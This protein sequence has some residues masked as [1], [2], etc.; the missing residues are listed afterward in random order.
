[1]PFSYNPTN[2]DKIVFKRLSDGCSRFMFFTIGLIF[3][4]V[5]GCM[6]YFMKSNEMPF[7]LFKYLLPAFGIGA[8]YIGIILPKMQR[9]STPDEI[10]FDNL[11][12][13]VEINQKESEINTAYIYYDEIQGFDV[14]VKS[15]TN[16]SGKRTNTHYTYHVQLNKKDGGHWELL[17]INSEL[18]AQTEITKLTSLIKLST[19]PKKVAVCLHP[20][21]KYTIT[22][23]YQKVE[24]NW[25][26][27]LGAGPLVLGIFSIVFITVLYG[28]M[29]T[30]SSMSAELPLFGIFIGSFIVIVFLIVII[31]N[32]M[33]MIKN[34]KTDYAVAITRSYF[35][36]FEKDHSGRI[37]REDRFPFEELHAIAFSFDTEEAMRKIYIYTKKQYEKKREMKPSFSIDYITSVFEFQNSLIALD[38]QSL[39]AVE[40]LHIENYLQEQIKEIGNAE[41]A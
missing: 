2:P 20:S 21:K 22:T 5:G 23:G 19:P 24:L 33:K 31:G 40:A 4:I 35:T 34:A 28:I 1:M 10:I 36:Y 41:V 13:R 9:K 3:T 30:M 8:M 15:H 14:I 12:G 29:S 27:K 18:D 11:N 17:K 16:S 32:A 37:K 7:V 6:L 26:N 38:M 25:R 39:T